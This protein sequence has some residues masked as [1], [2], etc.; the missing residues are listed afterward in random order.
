MN[1][2]ARD[3]ITLELRAR[4]SG[5]TAD[6]AEVRLVD[7]ETVDVLV[8]DENEPGYC[9]DASFTVAENSAVGRAVGEMLSED[10][11]DDDEHT[12]S[13][14]SQPSTAT[15]DLTPFTIGIT[16]GQIEVNTADLDLETRGEYAVAVNVTD[17][18]GLVGHCIATIKLLNRNERPTI[19]P[20]TRL[21]VPA[22]TTVTIGPPLSQE[23]LRDQD[24]AAPGITESHTWAIA[25]G[26]TDNTFEIDETSGQI[27]VANNA[28]NALIYPT[29][30]P[31]PMH[32]LNVTVTDA[33]IDGPKLS[34]TATVEIEVVD[35]NF[36]PR[37]N[38][39]F[40]FTLN[41]NT[42]IGT[43]VGTVAGY[44]SDVG[45]SLTFSLRPGGPNVNRPFPF[46][47][48]NAG[49]SGSVGTFAAHIKVATAEGG[50]DFEGPRKGRFN[51]YEAIVTAVDNHP[52]SP[53]SASRTV[54]ITLVD[55][56]E[57]PVFAR[58]QTVAD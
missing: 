17:K 56:N 18:G 58:G 5:N 25:S 2:E 34:F 48:E 57:A 4:D 7:E 54:I 49:S 44:D 51:R 21:F 28:T 39:P 46:E 15:G 16:T 29:G 32:R 38:G 12:W 45:Q 22:K 1:H 42:V 37:I 33:G 6:G 3:S 8:M 26:N 27:G 23:Y 40:A 50:V 47:I 41:E 30:G 14:A 20:V 11:D 9:F 53:L 52:D 43:E 55:L 24:L 19:L 10:P 13:I 31:G 35:K 36:P